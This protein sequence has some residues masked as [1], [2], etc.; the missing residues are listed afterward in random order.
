MVFMLEHII[1][2]NKNIIKINYYTS[3]KKV[4]KMLSMNYWKATE[5]LVRLKDITTHLKD[6]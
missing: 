3:I 2:I 6:L 4:Q 5:T 1:Q